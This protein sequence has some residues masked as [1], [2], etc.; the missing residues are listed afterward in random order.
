MIMGLHGPFHS[1][2][3]AMPL[4]LFLSIHDT[5]LKLCPSGKHY[6]EAT[7]TMDQVSSLPAL[8]V[9]LEWGEAE[10]VIVVE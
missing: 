8:R 5:F 1:H 10:V 2:V 7:L 6:K 9:S 4:F 3:T